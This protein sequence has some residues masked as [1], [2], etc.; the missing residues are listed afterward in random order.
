[1]Y[2]CDILPINVDVWCEVGVEAHLFP[3]GFLV[4]STPFVKKPPFP[5]LDALALLS[6]IRRPFKC[7]SVT[8]SLFCSINLFLDSYAG[9][10][11][12]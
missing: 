3:Y 1:M 9:T 7:G 11:L 8:A 2:V 6:E 12:S 10:I 5:L 4:V